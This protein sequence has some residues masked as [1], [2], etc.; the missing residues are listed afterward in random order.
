MFWLVLIGVCQR[1]LVAAYLAGSTMHGMVLHLLLLHLTENFWSGL[2]R[3]VLR[4]R[5]W[6]V[7]MPVFL[8]PMER[9]RVSLDYRVT[10]SIFHWMS[11]I[12]GQLFAVFRLFSSIWRPL[13]PFNIISKLQTWRTGL[14]FFFQSLSEKKETKKKNN[15]KKEKHFFVNWMR[16]SKIIE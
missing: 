14:L 6:P 7:R 13:I 2:D 12:Y 3:F 10:T 11:I 1:L 8:F 9:D 5:S 16:T 4:Q 15:K